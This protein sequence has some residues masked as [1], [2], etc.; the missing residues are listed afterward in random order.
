M[1][2]L[3][4][5]IP[6]PLPAAWA[7]DASLRHRLERVLRLS[8]DAELVAADGQGRS[9]P[10]RWRATE[11]IVSGPQQLAPPPPFSLV[12]AAGLIKGERW[13]WLVEKAAELGVDE[14]QPL[15]CDHCVVRVDP[16]KASDKTAR[17]QAIAQEAF[18]QCG[19]PWLCRVAQPRSLSAWLRTLGPGDTVLACDERLPP[20]TL[21]EALLKLAGE[22][23]LARVAVVLGP[24]GGLSAQEWQALDEYGAVRVQ[25]S[26]Q[27]LR[28]ETAGL[29]A[30][31][32][33]AGLRDRLQKQSSVQQS[34]FEHD[35]Q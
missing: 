6:R 16:A 21:A 15:A 32:I 18:E 2:Q 17:W 23:P 24:E 27:V 1:R 28:S 34:V 3:L 33:V 22:R 25:L 7:I 31:V 30:A 20:T 12:V 9:V 14:L 19:R 8:H 13:D 35:F 29:A 5:D 11:L 26:R 4:L 10:V